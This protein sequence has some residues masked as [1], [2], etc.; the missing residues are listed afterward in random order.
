MQ[1]VTLLF[2]YRSFTAAGGVLKKKKNSDSKIESLR[3][4]DCNINVS[5]E[6]SKYFQIFQKEKKKRPQNT[7][8]GFMQLTGVNQL[9]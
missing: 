9:C 7:T 8:N 1:T 5:M 4:F 3:L 2:T 6:I